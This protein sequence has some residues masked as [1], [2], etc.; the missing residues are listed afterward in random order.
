MLGAKVIDQGPG[1]RVKVALIA[2]AEA[3]VADQA[4]QRESASGSRRQSGSRKS[5]A[6][7]M[8]AQRPPRI[9]SNCAANPSCSQFGNAS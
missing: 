3:G 6:R 7:L 1:L 4:L 5:W 2:A 8:P 9:T